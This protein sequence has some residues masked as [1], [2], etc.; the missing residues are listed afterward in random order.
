MVAESKPH[1]DVRHFEEITQL[2]PGGKARPADTAMALVQLA[3]AYWAARC[4][5]TVAELGV[6]DALDEQPR[7]AADLAQA[8]GANP[9]A[10]DRVL[11]LLV[12]E[13]IFERRDGRYG[14]NG[15]SRAL[16]S[17]HPHSLRAYVRFV[18]APIFWESYGAMGHVLR[19]GNTGVSTIEPR[20]VFQYFKDHPEISEIFDGAM[21]GKA[22]SAIQ[23][24][25]SVYDFSAFQTVGDIGGGL[26]HLLKAILQK[27]PK[28]KGVLF[29]QQHVV[30]NVVPAERLELQ[31][32]DFFRG[33]L[34]KCDAYVLMEVLHDW[35]DAECIQILQQVR[36]A[37]PST[38][39]LLVIETVLPSEAQPHFA[40][41]LDIAMMV[42]T[43]G[44][45]RTSD[46]LSQLFGQSG[47]RLMR[48]IPTTSPYTIVEA[49]VE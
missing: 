6:P 27:T 33:P 1:Q 19:T 36:K 2:S 16:R 49:V 23:P 24:V 44:R 20:G 8:V 47:F 18:G 4:L 48:V 45:E 21:R 34:P 9:D 12:S 29:D 14:H 15:L 40:H 10:L 11:R 39:R 30:Q 7:T 37:A 41:H 13:G 28:T 26:G 31:G 25:L 32:G 17:D 22:E 35:T 5:H 46:Q 42:M 43:G 3:T 38:A